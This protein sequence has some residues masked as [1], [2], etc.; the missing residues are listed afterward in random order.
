MNFKSLDWTKKEKQ[1]P[2]KSTKACK[3][4]VEER[5]DEIIEGKV[6]LTNKVVETLVDVKQK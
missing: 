1:I 4:T 2:R 6:K 5:L 3:N